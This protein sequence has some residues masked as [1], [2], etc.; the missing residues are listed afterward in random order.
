MIQFESPAQKATFEKIV[1]WMKDLF[2]SFAGQREDAPA[3]SVSVGSAMALTMVYP[4]RDDE[5]VI[6]TRA[7]VVTGAELTPE[8]MHYLLREN[9]R[10]SFG[11]FGIDPDGD[12]FF[13]HTILGSTCDQPELKS[14]VLSVVL[15]ADEYDDEIVSRWGGQRAIDR[16]AKTAPA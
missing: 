1:P 13:E 6:S 8:L 15:V 14:S 10:M 7:W 2:G 4:W 5:A 3:F 9:D 12:I 11:A 16:V